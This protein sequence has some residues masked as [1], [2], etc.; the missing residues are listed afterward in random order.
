MKG[1]FLVMFIGDAKKI[2]PNPKFVAKRALIKAQC[3][4]SE[5]V[6]S[7][8]MGFPVFGIFVVTLLFWIFLLS[9]K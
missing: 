9:C 3:L 1:V 2:H 6:N 5:N 8:S 7:E 4:E